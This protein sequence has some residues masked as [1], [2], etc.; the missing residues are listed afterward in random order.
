MMNYKSSFHIKQN[1]FT[2]NLN[3][4]IKDEI[5]ILYEIAYVEPTSLSA[6]N[7]NSSALLF[8]CVTYVITCL[9]QT[10]DKQATDTTWCPCTDQVFIAAEE[11]LKMSYSGVWDNDQE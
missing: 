9:I 5:L 8:Y 1:T 10:V 7:L 3:V 2:C 11:H 6:F 4:I